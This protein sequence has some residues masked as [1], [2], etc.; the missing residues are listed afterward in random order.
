MA[1]PAATGTADYRHRGK[2]SSLK[3]K[4]HVNGTPSVK[5]DT[6]VLK[7][8]GTSGNPP[9]PIQPDKNPPSLHRMGQYTWNQQ[10]RK[11]DA[12]FAVYVMGWET[13]DSG[14]NKWRYWIRPHG[15]G[16]VSDM[17]CYFH[18]DIRACYQG[19]ERLRR[20]KLYLT[21]ETCKD[22]YEVVEKTKKVSVRDKDLNFAIM[23]AC[24][25]VKGVSHKDI[26][27][28]ISNQ[29]DWTAKAAKRKDNGS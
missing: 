28:G 29:D 19:V 9:E 4:Q 7:E 20:Q 6:K 2:L 17:L 18:D 22:G 12:L 11:L 14:H 15:K 3:G 24:L 21:V 23:A 25:L 26:Q 27:E 10:D 16:W 1:D 13:K 5:L 8:T